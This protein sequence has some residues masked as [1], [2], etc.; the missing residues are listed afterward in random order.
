VQQKNIDQ[1]VE[2]ISQDFRSISTSMERLERND[3]G[4]FIVPDTVLS[5]MVGVLQ[6]VVAGLQKA[7]SEY[8]IR[9]YQNS[10]LADM[11]GNPL[12]ISPYSDK[13]Q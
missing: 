4:D 7:Q 11:G 13:D 1:I 9:Q 8:A 6:N 5:C 2:R 3:E 12:G 10:L